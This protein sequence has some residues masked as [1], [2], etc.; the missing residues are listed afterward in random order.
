VSYSLGT[1]ATASSTESVRPSSMSAVHAG[2]STTSRSRPH[3]SHVSIVPA[4]P[5]PALRN[6]ASVRLEHNGQSITGRHVSLTLRPLAPQIPESRA[7]KLRPNAGSFVVDPL[8]PA[9]GTWEAQGLAAVEHRPL[10]APREPEPATVHVHP[11]ST[12]EPERTSPGSDPSIGEGEGR[13]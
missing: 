11:R 7:H 3:T 8:S 1:S 12:A 5:R 10:P 4:G 9:A 2:S 13:A 6:A